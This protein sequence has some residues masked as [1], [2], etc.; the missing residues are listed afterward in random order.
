[1]SVDIDLRTQTAATDRERLFDALDSIDQGD[2][3]V[4]VADGDVEQFLCDYQ[5]ARERTLSWEYDS[6]SEPR[7]IRV[8]KG[9]TVDGYS[10]FDVRAM[11]PQRRHAVLLETF[12]A[13]APDEGFVLVNDHDPKPLSY[14]LRSVWGDTFDWEY[15][16]EGGNEWKV[17]IV[18][19]EQAAATESEVRTTFDVR[20]IPKQERHPTIHHRYGTLPAGAA[21]E[22]IAPHEP[23]PLRREFQQ[24]Y[25]DGF[26]WEIQEQ[27]R[28]RCR[29]RITKE[30]ER[31][32]ESTAESGADHGHDDGPTTGDGSTDDLEVTAELDVRDRPPAERHRQ[33]FDAYDGLT[34]GEAFVLVNDHDP[35]PLY[36]QFEAEAGNA[37]RWEYRQ[38]EAGEFRVRIGEAETTTSSETGS[39]GGETGG[40][41]PDDIEAPF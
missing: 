31:A 6:E 39:D 10:E 2:H 7:K 17:E 8:Q 38:R 41:G 4:V 22:I 15:S 11:P 23:R 33:I 1:M 13:L 9:E 40:A 27:E 21:M 24:R 14:E 30:V 32:G 5:I 37:F 19:T 36:H 20:D 18:K 29:V 25:G 12:E 28:G 35:K 26:M 3:V 16:A 34:P